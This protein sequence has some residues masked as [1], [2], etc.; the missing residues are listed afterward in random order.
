[1]AKIDPD[2]RVLEVLDSKEAKTNM[3]ACPFNRK[4]ERLFHPDFESKQPSLLLNGE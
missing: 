3:S 2:R 1:M 4:M